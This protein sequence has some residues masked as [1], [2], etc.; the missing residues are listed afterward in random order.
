M[1]KLLKSLLSPSRSLA[2][3]LSNFPKAVRDAIK[4]LYMDIDMTSDVK[5]ITPEIADYLLSNCTYDRQRP[6]R[7]AT[8]SNL[9]MMFE[10]GSCRP[11]SQVCAALV[12]D[13]LQVIDGRHRLTLLSSMKVSMP[14]TLTV[15]HCR[16]M[17]QVH[18]LYI[19]F[20]NGIGNR[21]LADMYA[22]YF[23]RATLSDP[24]RTAVGHVLSA[25]SR[26]LCM[27]SENVAKASTHNVK[28]RCLMAHKLMPEMRA[29]RKILKAGNIRHSSVTKQATLA[30]A[31]LTLKWKPKEAT[32][33]W[34]AV[35]SGDFNGQGDPCFALRT[36]LDGQVKIPSRNASG[37]RQQKNPRQRSQ[38]TA[39]CW[40]KFFK[41]ERINSANAEEGAGDQHD[42]ILIA[43]T[44]FKNARMSKLF[45]RGLAA[46]GVSAAQFALLQKHGRRSGTLSISGGRK[47]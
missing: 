40:N 32:A 30:V 21:S 37:Q 44:T 1:E 45:I 15:Y 16:S 41:G 11:G 36:F 20:D 8:L 17:K 4:K 6:L 14:I 7:G 24:G 10:G 22:A 26:I 46:I 12:G 23:G 13:F 5:V 43:G 27:F 42:P 38:I 25:T 33:F 34:T 28:L 2:P 29:L 19:T 47:K 31:L 9:G 39:N 35:T 3:A 18:D